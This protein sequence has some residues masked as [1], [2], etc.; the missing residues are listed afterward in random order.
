MLDRILRT[1]RRRDLLLVCCGVQQNLFADVPVVDVSLYEPRNGH[2]QQHQDVDG[3]EDLVNG[4]R[5]FHSKCQNPFKDQS[6]GC[7]L[8]RTV[9]SVT[10]LTK[11]VC[12]WEEQDETRSKDI[13]VRGQSRQPHGGI[14]FKIFRYDPS[15]KVI[16]CPAPRQCNTGRSWL[17]GCNNLVKRSNKETRKK[18]FYFCC[19][20]G[21]IKINSRIKEKPKRFFQLFKKIVIKQFIRKLFSQHVMIK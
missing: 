3:C 2:K 6:S 7:L 4:G 20:V 21:L 18:V 11:P 1:N 10:T 19:F 13:R 12:T 5:L 14:F 15:N 8:N 17:K 16:K 9:S